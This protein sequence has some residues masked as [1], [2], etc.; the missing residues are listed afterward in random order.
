MAVSRAESNKIIYVLVFAVAFFISAFYLDVPPSIL[1]GI[2]LFLLASISLPLFSLA[3]KWW[4]P[5]ILG[6]IILLP[7]PMDRIFISAE[8][9]PEGGTKPFGIF[10]VI[11]ILMCLSIFI[12]LRASGRLQDFFNP[13]INRLTISLMIIT[14][15]SG[16][17]AFLSYL[18]YPYFYLPMA[19]RAIFYSIRFTLVFAW[20][21]LFFDDLSAIRKMHIPFYLITTGFFLLA[22]LSP[23]ENYEGGN[24]LSVATY[25]VNTFGHLLAMI[26]LFSIPFLMHFRKIRRYTLLLQTFICFAICFI[27]LMMSANRM[28]FLLLVFGFGLYFLIFPM[29][30]RSKWRLA[31]TM[32]FFTAL[33]FG[34]FA[35]IQ[36][37]L[38]GRIVGVFDIM[39]GENAVENIS[40]LQAR[41]VVWNISFNMIIESPLFGVGPGQWNYL[42]HSFG[43]FPPWMT[44]ILDPHNGYLLYASEMGLIC[45]VIY[46][47]III[48]CIRKGFRAFKYL[49]KLYKAHP[50]EE[51]RLY[52]SF[53]LMISIIVICW[54]LSDL[55]NASGLNIR[56]QSLMWSFCSMLFLGPSLVK[57]YSKAKVASD[58]L[59]Q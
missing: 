18:N 13:R 19:F 10:S 29:P 7:G 5:M 14:I 42:K 46:Y 6:L 35:V 43:S 23:K 58:G 56:V 49:K 32:L 59:L 22:L 2:Y 47:S 16:V 45:L 8:I 28:S 11:D 51:V 48:T 12:R 33:G 3:S 54:L 38:F 20:I 24:R 55:S 34:I 50:S 25:G 26:S 4:L 1:L 15:L 21:T 27:F 39:S 30:V 44:Q 36:P 57:K 53:Y 40:E 9:T 41:F 17:S 37:E 52:M 31:L